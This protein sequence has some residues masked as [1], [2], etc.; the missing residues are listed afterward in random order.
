MQL[1]GGAE[2]E[3]KEGQQK[4][5]WQMILCHKVFISDTVYPS[6]TTENNHDVIKTIIIIRDYTLQHKQHNMQAMH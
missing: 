4:S 3:E 6:K 5:C 2:E 1:R